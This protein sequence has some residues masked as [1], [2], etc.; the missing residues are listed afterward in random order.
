MRAMAS[1]KYDVVIV[2]AGPAGITAA[3]ALAKAGVPVLVIEAS[4][5]PARK[6]GR[7]RSFRRNLAQSDVLGEEAVRHSAYE[8]PV[9]KRG[10]YIYNG[11]LT[12]RP[13][14]S[15]SRHLRELLHRPAPDLR[16]LPRRTCE[17][18]RRAYS[19]RKPPPTACSATR[20]TTSSAFT[21]TAAPSI[22]VLPRVPRRRR[23]VAT[24]L[25]GRLRMRHRPRRAAF[26]QGIKEITV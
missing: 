7:A 16:S 2:G 23:C 24:R 1:W 20:T 18:F 19:R 14:L 22:Y 5:F 11:R 3:I 10:F 17:I 15:E 9:T 21:P 25:Q 6:T 12:R 13:Q 8:R 4:C 26:L